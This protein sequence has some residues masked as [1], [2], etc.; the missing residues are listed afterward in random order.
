MTSATGILAA[1]APTGGAVQKGDLIGGVPDYNATLNLEQSIGLPDLWDGFARADVDFVGSSHGSV[2]QYQIGSTSLDP[3]YRRP[4]YH[5][6]N[7]TLGAENG[8]WQFTLFAANLFNEQKIIQQVNV[9]YAYEAYR[10]TPRTV[11][12]SV[13]YGF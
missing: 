13:R 9:Q 12:V 4:S 7:A 8:A 10:P 5:I 3:D 2:S 6:V 11:G 1:P